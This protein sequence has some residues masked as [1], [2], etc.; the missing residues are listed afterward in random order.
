MN[1]AR[2]AVVCCLL[3]TAAGLML[4]AGCNRTPQLNGDE[5]CLGVADA[6]WTAITAKRLELTDQCATKIEALHA[7]AKMPDEAFEILM[8]VI[9][10][11]RAGHWAEARIALKEFVRGQRPAPPRA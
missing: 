2:S 7:A 5:E 11:A 1:F 9:S 8:G 4:V 6:L 3:S 10:T